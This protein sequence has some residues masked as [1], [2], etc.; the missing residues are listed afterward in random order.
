MKTLMRKKAME[1]VINTTV[2]TVESRQLRRGDDTKL[3]QDHRMDLASVDAMLRDNKKL[4]S[5]IQLVDGRWG[6]VWMHHSSQH[7]VALTLSPLVL[8]RA[9]LNYYFW[10]RNLASNPELHNR[11]PVAAAALLLLPLIHI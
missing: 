3:F 6:V 10:E 4:I 7:L 9:G 5:C 1:C 2:G 8:T 11:Q